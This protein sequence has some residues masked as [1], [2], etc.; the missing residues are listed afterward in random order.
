MLFRCICACRVISALCLV[1][2]LFLC[3]CVWFVSVCVS[4]AASASVT[5]CWIFIVVYVS[6]LPSFSV[7]VVGVGLVVGVVAADAAVAEGAS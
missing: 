3:I 1:I 6:D 7:Y 5:R 4:I 2:W